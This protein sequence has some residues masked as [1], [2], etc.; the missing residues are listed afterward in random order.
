MDRQRR[1][2]MAQLRGDE[3]IVG[4]SPDVAMETPLM[5]PD[6]LSHS[7]GRGYQ[8]AVNRTWAAFNKVGCDVLRNRFDLELIFLIESF[9]A[10]SR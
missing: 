5:T 8:K 9:L 7:G 6:V 3:W 10:G 4:T 1:F 2:T